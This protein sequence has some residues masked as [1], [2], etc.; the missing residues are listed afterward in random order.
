MRVAT[1]VEST[2]D[3]N[4]GAA[5]TGDDKPMRGAPGDFSPLRGN[6]AAENRKFLR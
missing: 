1:P 4:L 3:A 2:A 5:I 6:G